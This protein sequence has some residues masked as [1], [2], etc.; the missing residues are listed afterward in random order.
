MVRG[1]QCPEIGPRSQNFKIFTFSRGQCAQTLCDSGSEPILFCTSRRP[2]VSAPWP[3][4]SEKNSEFSPKIDD[5]SS[6]AKM[7]SEKKVGAM[8]AYPPYMGQKTDG[9]LETACDHKYGLVAPGF[10]I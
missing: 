3:I 4:S 10:L 6:Y 8:R 5:V 2:L 7:G 9:W 1:L